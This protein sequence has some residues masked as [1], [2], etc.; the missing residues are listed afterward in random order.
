MGV[1]GLFGALYPRR[2]GP[3]KKARRVAGLM[4]GQ[5]C[6]LVLYALPVVL[7]LLQA[8]QQPPPPSRPDCICSAWPACKR[9]WPAH[10]AQPAARSPRC[11][12]D[13]RHQLPRHPLLP[14]S[15]MAAAA[16]APSAEAQHA[17]WK[18]NVPYL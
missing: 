11:G 14:P 10:A 5:R 1:Q 9:A 4:R 16:A 7:E 15:A 8:S 13:C 6:I 2:L 18:K 17:L 3:G 12:S